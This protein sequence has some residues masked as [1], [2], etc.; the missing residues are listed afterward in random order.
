[1]DEIKAMSTVLQLSSFQ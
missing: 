1:M